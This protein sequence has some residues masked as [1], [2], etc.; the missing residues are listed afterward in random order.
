[1]ALKTE[2][3][4]GCHRATK[5][6]Y[7]KLRN[8]PLLRI[9]SFSGHAVS[10]PPCPFFTGDSMR[11]L[12]AVALMTSAVALTAGCANR[13]IRLDFVPTVDRLSPVVVENGDADIFTSS[14]IA[15]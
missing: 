4:L 14:K 11:K 1:M 5:P 13:T 15:M 2:G 7:R 9:V 6:A 12:A 10:L 8:T 3:N